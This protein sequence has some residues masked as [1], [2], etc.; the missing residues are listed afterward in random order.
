MVETLY[1]FNENKKDN[2][3]A[4][5]SKISFWITHIFQKSIL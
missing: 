4:T 3:L 2:N 5:L 1:N